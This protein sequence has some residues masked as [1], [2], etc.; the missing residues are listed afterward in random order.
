MK[1]LVL[2]SLC[3]LAGCTVG[4]DYS[5]PHIPQST[6]WRNAPVSAMPDSAWWTAFGDD[7]LDALEAEAMQGNLDLAQALSRIEQASAAARGAA[8][9]SWPALNLDGSLDRTQSSL[10]SR[11]GGMASALPGFQRTTSQ[12][13]LGISTAW[14]LD[15]AGGIRR[16]KE[17]ARATLDATRAAGEA[18]RMAVSAE[19]ADAYF[20]AGALQAQREAAGQN[21]ALVEAQVALLRRRLEAGDASRMEVSTALAGLHQAKAQLPVLD[22]GIEAQRNRLALLLGRD[23]TNAN[24]PEIK[25]HNY[26]EAAA[27]G[28]GVPTDLLRRRPDVRLAEWRLVAANAGIGATLAEFYPRFSLG[29]FAGQQS[30]LPG[31]LMS[32]GSRVLQGG[33]GLRWRLF[34]FG[35]IDS[36]LQAARGREREAL[37]AYRLAVLQA[38]ADVESAFAQLDGMRERLRQLELEYASVVSLQGMAITAFE[39]GAISRSEQLQADRRVASAGAELASARREVARAIIGC[40][41]ALGGPLPPPAP[42]PALAAADPV[43]PEF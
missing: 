4:P 1:H 8:S 26:S 22:A 37:A 33:L 36:Q 6:Q 28:A 21:V 20:A 41:R 15:F 31:D 40:A 2:V 43:R 34:D 14:D 17:A 16:Q 7:R 30:V 38:A 10:N 27:P 12:A 42:S 24:L 9:A 25:P 18:V 13:T 32:S 29:I 23:P 11:E 35:R 39:S 3:L 5:R 19:V